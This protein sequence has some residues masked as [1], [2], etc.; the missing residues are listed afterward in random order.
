[1][2]V[3]RS[4]GFSLVELMVV[5]LI[6]GILIVIAVPIFDASKGS[7]ELKTC[8]SN[9]REIE[10]AAQTY[11]AQTGSVPG[12]GTVG[13]THVLI[14]GGFIK[15]APVCPAGLQNYAVDSSGS[16]TAASLTCGHMHY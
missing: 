6:I 4:D 1:V 11:L 8:W 9:Q 2:K 5:V 13:P 14:A 15:K 16:V 10:G 12:A 3:L 7:A